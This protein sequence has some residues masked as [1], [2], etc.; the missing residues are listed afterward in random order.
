MKKSTSTRLGRKLTLIVFFASTSSLI[1]AFT[2][3]FYVEISSFKQRYEARLI[4]LANVIGNSSRAAILFGDVKTAD[5][6]LQAASSEGQILAVALYDSSGLLFTYHT[7]TSPTQRFPESVGNDEIVW[8][9]D[10]AQITH[11]IILDSERVGSITIISALNEMRGRIFRLV[12]LCITLLLAALAVA[13]GAALLL[14]RK[15]LNPIL[16]L[17]N[18]T[19][20][21]SEEGD[22]SQRVPERSD[23]EIGELFNGF[24]HMLT[25]IQQRDIELRSAIELAQAADLA[26]SQ[27]L[28]N[29]SHEIRT[30]LN[31]VIGMTDL[32]LDTKLSRDQQECLTIVRDSSGIL[33][34]V[35]NDILDFSKIEAG[36][37]DILPER[38]SLRESLS[39]LIALIEPRAQQARI[40]CSCM[41]GS[42]IPDFIVADENRVRQIVLNLVTNAIKFTPEGGKVDIQISL[43]SKDHSEGEIAIEVR[44]T[45]IGI[46][47]SKQQ[48]IFDAF[49]QV[50]SSLTRSFGG[51]GLGLAITHQLV[52]L[53]GG[54]LTLESEE[55][56]G[57]T[58]K[59]TL[60]ILIV[61][62]PSFHLLQT[63]YT[64][65]EPAKHFDFEAAS[66]A[67]DAH[68][69]SILVVDDNRTSAS[70]LNRFLTRHNHKVDVE[71]GGLAA[72][73]RL[74]QNQNYDLVLLDCQMPDLDGFS[75]V[76]AIRNHP[77]PRIRDLPVIAITALA[78]S[79]DRER[80][81]AAGM[82]GYCS[83]PIEFKKLIQE[84]NH[85]RLCVTSQLS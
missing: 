80:C 75:V 82:S 10:T 66:D 85:V 32:V 56:K 49:T 8:H 54:T 9:A 47:K 36:K 41:I 17:V 19:R 68:E 60:P 12:T 21:V 7:T 42:D 18:A 74:Q 34:N 24:N 84:I 69:L 40:S 61:D 4:G 63:K 2:G 13:S 76:K 14:K 59:I 72:L 35:I 79:G 43:A 31:G 5:S 29:M 30:P 15:I 58:F 33:L 28:A 6:L 22:Y 65:I 50:D 20:K 44:D 25:Q 16:Q 81:L 26:K 39:N 55:D 62:E 64:A 38:F 52:G 27:F 48:L 57:S 71:F 53:M 77:E 37:L 11:P 45:G 70:L 1:L 67:F 83:K 46:P 51:T 3:F 23:D 78:M 73:N